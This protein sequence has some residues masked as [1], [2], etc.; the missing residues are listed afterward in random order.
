MPATA[1]VA[2]THI[3]T[4]ARPSAI[5]GIRFPGIAAAYD[6][7]VLTLVEWVQAEDGRDWDQLRWYGTLRVHPNAR[8][9]EAMKKA[10]LGD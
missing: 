1:G 8:K 6:A 4:G 5:A 7:A 9:L 10:V 3:A 2:N